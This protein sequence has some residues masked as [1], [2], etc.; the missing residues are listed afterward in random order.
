MSAADTGN[1]FG[2]PDG[3]EIPSPHTRLEQLGRVA[4]WLGRFF[5]FRYTLRTMYGWRRR[6]LRLYGARIEAGAIVHRT[7][8]I[9]FPCRLEMETGACLGPR[10]RVYNLDAVHIGE[11]ATVSQDSTLCAATRDYTRP[12]MDLITR[13][14]T[15]GRGA[16]VAAEAFVGPGV[17]I[18]DNAV[19]GARSVVTRDMPDGMVCA[20]NP[21]R[22][23]KPR[24]AREPES[25][26]K[27][28]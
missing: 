10:V 27:A 9:E 4:W 21:C 1:E 5:L 18:G 6:V 23:F 8:S 25:G 11:F 28:P 16:W 12:G 7:V 14:I 13:P 2:Y 17:R 24:L 26:Q 20:G 22:P 19:I 15:I 3:R